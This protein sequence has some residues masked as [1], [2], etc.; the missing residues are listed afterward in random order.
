MFRTGKYLFLICLL[1]SL[2]SCGKDDDV[3][4]IEVQP[5]LEMLVCTS[6][7]N[8]YTECTTFNKVS[9]IVSI[10]AKKDEDCRKNYDYYLLDEKTVVVRN[11]CSASFILK[12]K[13]D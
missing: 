9:E 5:L 11:N 2:I 3:Q 10:L 8:A 12:I 7:N 4:E 13:R 6:K 1:F